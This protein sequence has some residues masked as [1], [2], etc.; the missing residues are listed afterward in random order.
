[1]PTQP[2]VRRVTGLL[3]RGKAAG[4]LSSAEIKE[5]VE[6]YSYSL[7]GILQG[8]HSSPFSYLVYFLRLIH[9]IFLSFLL[10]LPLSFLLV[11]MHFFRTF[12]YSSLL[13]CQGHVL[14][15]YR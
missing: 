14:A 8:E 12:L 5:R 10:H 6:L 7:S 4:A 1:M 2:P 3:L 15:R 13:V 11:L 9:L